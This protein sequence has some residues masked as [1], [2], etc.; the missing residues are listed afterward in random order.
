M[1]QTVSKLQQ[2][3]EYLANQLQPMIK[4]NNIDGWQSGGT[5]I[6]NGQDLGTGYLAANWKYDAV[7]QI[8]RIPH[9]R[10]NAYEMLAMLSVWLIENDSERDTYGLTDPDLD[11]DMISDDHAQ[12]T[13][14]LQLMDDIE[15]I[16]DPQGPIIFGGK[17]YR[18][19][20]APINVAESGEVQSRSASE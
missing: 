14:D 7:I 9:K 1:T 10:F 20:I 11:I 2:V 3:C 4:P 6:I 5:L 16:E 15:L 8:E 12:V 19:S 13:I 17:N 18:V